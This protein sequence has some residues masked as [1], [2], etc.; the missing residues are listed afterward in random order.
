MDA[1]DVEV[2]ELLTEGDELLVP[3]F[4]GRSRA[5]FDRLR[6]ITHRLCADYG[7]NGAALAR[8]WE[9]DRRTISLWRQQGAKL[10]DS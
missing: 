10:K 5:A 9:R 2:L 1:A 6:V 7:C 8:R 3:A 4:V